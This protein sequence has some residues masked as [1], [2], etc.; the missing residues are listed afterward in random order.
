[1][2]KQQQLK[3]TTK[4]KGPKKYKNKTIKQKNKEQINKIKQNKIQSENTIVNKKWNKPK[5]K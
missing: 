1:M 2:S 3:Q 5:C 4:H